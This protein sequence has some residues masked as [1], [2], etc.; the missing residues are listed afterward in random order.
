MSQKING[1]IITCRF[2]EA[3]WLDHVKDTSMLAQRIDSNC[4]SLEV[5]KTYLKHLEKL[6]E[7]AESNDAMKDYLFDAAVGKNQIPMDVAKEIFA[8]GAKD[9][10]FNSRLQSGISIGLLGVIVF[11]LMGEHFGWVH[12]LFGP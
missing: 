6:D 10:S 7:I 9:R 3:A 4:Q 8:Q 11:L 5:M 1:E 12:K 2:N